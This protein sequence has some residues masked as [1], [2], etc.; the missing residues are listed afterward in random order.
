M[1][2]KKRILIA[3][4]NWGLGH[5][6]RCIPVINALLAEGFVP[7]IAS[8][9]RA[10]LLLKEEFPELQFV[11][12]PSY[13]IRYAKKGSHLKFKLLQNS[14]KT[15]KA[16]SKERTLIKTLIKEDAIDG[17]ISDNRFGVYSKK[18]PSVFITHQLK[19]MSGIT[20]WMSTKMHDKLISKYDECW[21]P[22]APSSHNLSGDLGHIKK[23]IIPI[24]YIGPMTRFKTESRK[25]LYDLMVLLSGPEPQRT[26]LEDHLLNELK[27]YKGSVL[28]VR[29][30]VELQQDIKKE[31]DL[32][33][34]NYM[35]SSQLQDA[36]N[37]SEL[38][39][40]R[41]GY[42]T[43][44]DLAKLGK[45]AFFIPTPGQYEQEYLAK[46]FLDNGILP[47]CKQEEFTI[48]MLN[49]VNLYNGF[50]D[51]NFNVDFENLFNL[52]EGERK[53]TTNI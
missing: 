31:G 1:K 13:H 47:S 33:M 24:K 52:F 39:I 19:V 43:I 48:E 53:F 4:L 29:G 25:I 51:F 27:R 18:I 26:I 34:Y 28:F 46:R 2:L 44:M 42:T 49:S 8:D 12:L 41:S 36:I 30:C 17:I 21:V 38:I 45:R 11:E 7:I 37:E 5:A 35:T 22:D 6:T 23:N 15:L 50:K 40:S 9:G 16:I 14:P 32:I 10:L 3:P 20:T